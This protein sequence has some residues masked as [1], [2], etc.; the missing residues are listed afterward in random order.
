M[1]A[2]PN[3]RGV[4]LLDLDGTLVDSM[5]DLAGALNELRGELGR[6]PIPAVQVKPMGGDGVAKL[7]ERGLEHSGEPAPEAGTMAALVKRFLEIYETWLTLE[8][9]P[10]PGVPETLATLR[11]DG[12]RLA[13]CTNKPEAASRRILE[14]LGLALLF[15]IVSGGDSF[16]ERKPAAGHLLDTLAAM[17]ASAERAI[18]IGDGPND[19]LAGRN[20]GL[21]VV[22]VSY[23]YSKMPVDT[24]GA[25]AVI[26]RFAALPWALSKLKVYTK[27]H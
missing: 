24:L 13:L 2:V 9:R 22:L 19:L 1:A 18:M 11:R 23:G 4:L 3:G 16:A 27:G 5:A 25:D 12:W 15:E 6:E 21:P 10:Y 7:V 14:A 20:A 8:T 17:A 26:D